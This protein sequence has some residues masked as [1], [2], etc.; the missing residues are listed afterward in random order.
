M[1]VTVDEDNMNLK[2]AIISSL[3]TNGPVKLTNKLKIVAVQKNNEVTVKL[4]SNNN[5]AW[6][7][8]NTLD[9]IISDLE[10]EVFNFS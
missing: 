7:D 10:S 9:N 4:L 5:I 3:E 8:T 2:N 6:T 1:V